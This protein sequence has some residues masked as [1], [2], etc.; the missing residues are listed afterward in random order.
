RSVASQKALQYLIQGLRKRYGKQDAK[1]LV[2]RLL[3]NLDEVDLSLGD[4]NRFSGRHSTSA[5]IDISDEWAFSTSIDE[6][7]NTRS[8]VIFSLRFE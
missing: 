5:T 1:S 4:Y 3:K 6:E 8:I 2:Q 7:G